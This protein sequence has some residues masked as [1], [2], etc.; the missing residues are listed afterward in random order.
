MKTSTNSTI[1]VSQL[2]ELWSGVSYP[3]LLERESAVNNMKWMI[4]GLVKAGKIDQD[5]A[6]YLLVGLD[7]IRGY[8]E[9]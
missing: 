9:L 2:K 6:D 8:T 1:V 5:E 3:A 7:Y 4:R